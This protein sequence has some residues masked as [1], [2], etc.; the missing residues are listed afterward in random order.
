[1]NKINRLLS[2]YYDAIRHGEK[3]R[4]KVLCKKLWKLGVIVYP[5]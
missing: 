4:A 2:A 1:M 3:R 5:D